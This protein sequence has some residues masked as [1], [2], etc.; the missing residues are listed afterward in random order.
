MSPVGDLPTGS[1]DCVK[2]ISAAI[3]EHIAPV[4][5]TLTATDIEYIADTLSAKMI[6]ADGSSCE[7]AATIAGKVSSVTAVI[8]VGAVMLASAIV[9]VVFSALGTSATP[10]H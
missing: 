5:P 10:I 7:L 1:Q 4:M 3:F 9:G 8:G 2:R 6:I